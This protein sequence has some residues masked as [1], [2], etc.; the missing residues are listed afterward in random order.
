MH[1]FLVFA[2]PFNGSGEEILGELA[3]SNLEAAAQKNLI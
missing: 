1:L 3:K 2:L